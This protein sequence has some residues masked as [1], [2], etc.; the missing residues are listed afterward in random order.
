M[1]RDLVPARSARPNGTAFDEIEIAVGVGLQIE[2]EFVEIGG[3][4]GVVVE[5]LIEI[6]LAVAVQIVQPE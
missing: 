4:H 6:S 3:D 5:A 1:G 2:G